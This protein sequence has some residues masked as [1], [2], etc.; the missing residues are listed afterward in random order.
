MYTYHGYILYKAQIIFPQSLHQQHALSTSAWHA[1][2][3]SRETFAWSAGALHASVSLSWKTT[4][5]ESIH[6]SR[7][8]KDGTRRVLNRDCSEAVGFWPNPSNSLFRLLYCLHVAP[9]F[10]NSTNKIPS[11]SHIT[12]DMTSYRKSLHLQFVLPHPPYISDLAPSDFHL[13]MVS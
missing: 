4:S 8:R 12:L 1:V 5:S 2:C 6:P 9:P 3:R 11:L 7:V 10:K 13:F